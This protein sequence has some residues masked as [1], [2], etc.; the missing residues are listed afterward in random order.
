MLDAWEYPSHALRVRGLKQIG[1]CYKNRFIGSHALRVRGLK[2]PVRVFVGGI[3]RVARSTRAW[4]ETISSDVNRCSNVVA[5]STRA[6]IETTST[7]NGFRGLLTSHALR[8][9]GLKHLNCDSGEF[10]RGVARST[11]A[12]IETVL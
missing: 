11:R 1:A 8:V 2:Q 5:R 4:I 10:K 12:W 6:W 9:R 7:R 3:Y